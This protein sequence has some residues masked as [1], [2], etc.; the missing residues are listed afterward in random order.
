MLELTK[1][2]VDA[3]INSGQVF[4]WDKIDGSW[5]G[6]NGSE[7]FKITQDP[8]RIVSSEKKVS[9]FFRQ[10]DNIDKILSSIM[11][12][13]FVKDA[14]LR[15]PGLRLLRQDPFQC[16]ISFICSS[17]ASIQNI[18]KMLKKITRK[19]G[20]KI[21]FDNKEFHTFPSAQKLAK[22][23][24][25]ELLSCGLGFRAKYV[26]SAS[27]DVASGRIDFDSL[28][29]FNYQTAKDRLLQ[30]HGI[31]D[32]IADCI[33]LFSL[34]KIEAFPIDRWTLRILRKY[35][36]DLFDETIGKSITRKKYGAVHEKIVNHF[37]PFAGYSQ[38]FLFKMERELN[39]KK[40]L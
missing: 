40:W 6:I 38:Q 12:D 22:C 1:I 7:I 28:K 19:F 24:I 25:S 39:N 3:T 2:D 14:V 26:K 35:Y 8:F 15:F 32:K 27:Q 23:R 13:K 31:G 9:N 18:K 11:Q 30:V 5:F 10:D 4:L 36:F 17:N 29:K 20:K 37:G 33:L 34:E 21:I 16:Y